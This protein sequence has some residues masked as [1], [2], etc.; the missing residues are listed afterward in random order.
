MCASC[1][2]LPLLL[3]ACFVLPGDDADLGFCPPGERC[4]P[5]TPSGLIITPPSVFGVDDVELGNVPVAVGGTMELALALPASPSPRPLDLPY[6][7]T[8]GGAVDV[9][10][11]EGPSVTITGQKLGAT[12]MRIVDAEDGALFADR[13]VHG[14][15]VVKVEVLTERSRHGTAA[16]RPLAFAVG[17]HRIGVALLDADSD[18][19][20]GRR[21]VDS[22]MKLALD[23]ATQ[24]AWDTLTAVIATPGVRTLTATTGAG[25]PMTFEIPFVDHADL[26]ALF[27]EPP[28]FHGTRGDAE[29]YCFYPVTDGH[30]VA[31]STADWSFS[32]DTGTIRDLSISVPGCVEV[33]PSQLGMLHLTATALGASRTI[34]IVVNF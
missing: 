32:V 20:A 19:G 27:H 17:T 23:G 18:R 16:D 1:L 6:E 21:A 14:A 26:L 11:T 8:A 28:T 2:F 25:A 12:R 5:K 4:S 15:P 29:L 10:G 24:T 3:T 33:T 7:V 31:S 13:L 34:A 9:V 22:S 30:H